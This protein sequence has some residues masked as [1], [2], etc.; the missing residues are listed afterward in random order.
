MRFFLS[1]FPYRLRKYFKSS[2]VFFELNVIDIEIQLYGWICFLL[3]CFGM[4]EHIISWHCPQFRR[5]KKKL[6][7]KP[8]D[9]YSC[10]K[11]RMKI[12]KYSQMEERKGDLCWF[13]C[14]CGKRAIDWCN[15][16]NVFWRSSIE[17]RENLLWTQLCYLFNVI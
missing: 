12:F 1:C 14:V 7:E 15:A 10:K 5:R 3:L 6:K 13:M 2:K 4:L 9:K 17:F 16:S 11:M 8:I